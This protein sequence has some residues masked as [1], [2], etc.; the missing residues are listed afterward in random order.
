[1]PDGLVLHTQMLPFRCKPKI[2]GS[3]HLCLEPWCLQCCMHI[4]NHG[5]PRL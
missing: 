1:M 4:A 3:A 5:T 2:P